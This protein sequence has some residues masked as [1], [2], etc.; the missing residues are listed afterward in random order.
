MYICILSSRAGDAVIKF[1]FAK[2]KMEPAKEKSKADEIMGTKIAF[3]KLKQQLK[4]LMDDPAACK[5]FLDEVASMKARRIK[6][7]T[8]KFHANNKIMRS[9]I[10]L[11]RPSH[12]SVS[13]YKQSVV[14]V[15]KETIDFENR[16]MRIF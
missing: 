4:E 10:L 13:E 14:S 3:S 15:K 5:E 16:K 9:E 6:S 8:E 1:T 7:I 12:M 11:S 2:D